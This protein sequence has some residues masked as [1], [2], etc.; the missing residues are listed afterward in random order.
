[1]EFT[2]QYF[3]EQ[4]LA[5]TKG[6]KNL[7]PEVKRAVKKA[8][9]DMGIHDYSFS[10]RS[11][12][13]IYAEEH[14]L[15][16]KETALLALIHDKTKRPDDVKELEKTKKMIEA[17]D[18]DLAQAI[19]DY[20]TALAKSYKEAAA[21]GE[22]MSTVPPTRRAFN[23]PQ[24]LHRLKE[25]GRKHD[26]INYRINWG[27]WYDSPKNRTRFCET[28][29]IK[30]R[31]FQKIKKKL[32]DIGA[33]AHETAIQAATQ[34]TNPAYVSKVP[35]N[36]K[37]QSYYTILSD[38]QVF[39]YIP[40]EKLNVE[41]TLL[42]KAFLSVIYLFM[43]GKDNET[44]KGKDK[45][46]TSSESNPEG[47]IDPAYVRKYSVRQRQHKRCRKNVKT[48]GLGE[49]WKDFH[50]G[51]RH[52]CEIL[53]CSPTT[54]T[55]LRKKWS[56]IVTQVRRPKRTS[57][58]YFKLD[59]ERLKKEYPLNETCL[60]AFYD[61]FRE[62]MLELFDRIDTILNG[63]ENL[64]KLKKQSEYISHEEANEYKRLCQEN[65]TEKFL[66]SSELGT[67]RA[68]KRERWYELNAKAGAAARELNTV[69]ILSSHNTWQSYL[70]RN[71]H[72]FP[73]IMRHSTVAAPTLT[74]A[75]SPPQAAYSPP[76]VASVRPPVTS[77]RPFNGTDAF[78]PDAVAL[79][80][81]SPVRT[82]AKP[83]SPQYEY[84]KVY[85]DPRGLL[86]TPTRS[87][88]LVPYNGVIHSTPHT[89]R[90]EEPVVF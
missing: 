87:G 68:T 53:R 2:A 73:D 17:I 58:Y 42:D 3:A 75:H 51:T 85:R 88:E 45:K 54:L 69:G 19:K 65:E 11:D 74:E 61:G 16:I 14:G 56:F 48:D 79:A 30:T 60:D 40:P 27:A 70:K 5:V 6:Q 82:P 89:P 64:E 77:S 90:P 52:F 44:T 18:K 25:Y 13:L 76:Q 12:V 10:F 86:W 15:T 9:K 84:G 22:L 35:R 43:L 39:G 7:T 28:V 33:I 67:A 37:H 63:E 81:S 57:L 1:M 72:R 80:F 55:A 8:R 34:S 4:L 36:N 71:P 20:D 38:F 29:G 46:A 50:V 41:V 66:N 47:Q 49:D 23:I 32:L 59:R 24:F 78:H 83:P 21:R 31:Q 62:P 26:S